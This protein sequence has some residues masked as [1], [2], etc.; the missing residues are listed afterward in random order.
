MAVKICPECG[1]KVAQ[2][3]TTCIHCGYDFESLFRYCQECGCRVSDD[4]EECPECG[5]YELGETICSE[6]NSYE[7]NNN[8]NE[9]ENKEKC[10]EVFQPFT[11]D[12]IIAK[13]TYIIPNEDE[14][15][16]IEVVMVETG[17]YILLRSK[18]I[19]YINIRVIKCVH[20]SDGFWGN[21]S[22]Y[23]QCN[24]IEYVFISDQLR[25]NSSCYEDY[26]ILCF[27]KDIPYFI[28]NIGSKTIR[29]NL[30]IK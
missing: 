2:T 28:Y 25:K 6:G 15:T 27:G 20:D 24:S 18:E 21:D 4:V 23:K 26:F 29:T 8:F 3:R 13:E 17:L 12:E 9:E 16:M 19:K 7:E 5:S 1:G 30:E 11:L 14:F 10:V 22:F